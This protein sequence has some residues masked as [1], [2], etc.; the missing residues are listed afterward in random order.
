MSSRSFEIKMFFFVNEDLDKVNK[1]WI[2][3]GIYT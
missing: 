2:E 3:T 1:S